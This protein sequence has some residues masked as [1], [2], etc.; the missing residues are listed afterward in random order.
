MHLDDIEGIIADIAAGKMVILVDDED[1]ENEG[2]IIVAADKITPD[3]VNFMATH[4]RGLICLTITEE[5]AQQLNLSPM[6]RN[7]TEAFGTNFTVS[8][9]AAA[10]ITTGISASDRA[11]TIKAAIGEN[12]TPADIVSPG[13]IFPVVAKEGGVLVR[14]GHTEAGCDLARLAGLEPSCAIVEVLNEDGTMARR[15]QLEEFA[16]KHDIKLGTI[17]DLI[18]Y[19]LANEGIVEKVDSREFETEY[20]LFELHVYKD[21]VDKQ[22]HYALC[23]GDVS[24]S[25]EALVRVHNIR[26]P[27]DILFAQSKGCTIQKALEHIANSDMA[28]VLL[29]IG[30]PDSLALPSQ[31]AVK[32]KNAR[33]QEIGIGSQ[34]LRELGVEKMKLISSTA[35]PYHSLSGFGLE[36]TEYQVIN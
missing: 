21:I 29:C 8:I 27:E 12:A 11:T 4:G 1:R 7:N 25:D 14:A 13:H 18:K 6:V 2:D 28:G 22:L 30:K 19:R 23:K 3:L 33:T 26:L 20:G 10:G 5:R 32:I 16:K 17:A 15:P 34:I 35:A 24:E 36:I 31:D 9:E